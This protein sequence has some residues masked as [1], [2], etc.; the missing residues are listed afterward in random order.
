MDKNLTI[1]SEYN[2]I[3]I[4]VVVWDDVGIIMDQVKNI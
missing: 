2:P 3:S 4:N 1:D